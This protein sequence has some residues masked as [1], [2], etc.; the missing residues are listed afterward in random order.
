MGTFQLRRRRARDID[1]LRRLADYAI[2]RHHPAADAENPY[3]ALLESVVAITGG[4]GGAL[5][6]DR[7]RARAMN[8]D[9][10][11]SGETIDYGLCVHEAFD[12]ATVFSSIDQW[13]RYA[14][15]IGRWS[16]NESARFAETLLP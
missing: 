11:S 16:P 12:P 14:M 8:T 10:T 1:L 7:L 3:V 5:D 2:D 15:A 13:G 4:A 9:N 6:A